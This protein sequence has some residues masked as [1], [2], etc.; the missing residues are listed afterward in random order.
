MKKFG[1][2]LI[3]L[4]VVI[5]IIAVLMAV[6]IPALGRARAIAKALSSMSNMRQWG[7]GAVMVTNDNNGR[8]PWE[9]NKDDNMA[10]NFKNDNWWANSVPIML[11]QRSY[12]EISE[13]AVRDNS[14]VPLPPVSDSIF[15]D[16]AAK[17]PSQYQKS[18]VR[19]Y[20]RSSNY[21]YQLFFCYVWNSELNNGPTPSPHDD[22][23][24]VNIANINRSSETA[25]MVEMR[26]TNEELEASDYEYYRIRHLLGRHRGDWKRLARRHLGGSHITFV[27]GHTERV[28]YDWAT[29]NQQGSR[30]PDYSNGDWNK[31]GLIWNAFGP[32]L[33]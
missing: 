4:L 12:R 26:T 20:D 28:D 32:S 30:N 8:L 16:P 21:E 25:L 5:S 23:K 13:Q 27:D 6:S 15:I 31:Q 29:T 18:V 2:T 22:I 11:G 7:V 1:F 17:F 9:G 3:E 19:F 33:K 24:N 10:Q 14:F